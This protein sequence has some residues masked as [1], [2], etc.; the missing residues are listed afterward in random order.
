MKSP[1]VL[2]LCFSFRSAISSVPCYKSAILFQAWVVERMGRFHRVLEPG[3]NVLIP[4][5][6]KVKYVQS[7]KE[8]AIDVPKQGAITSGMLLV[9][10]SGEIVRQFFHYF[11][12]TV[13][14]ITTSQSY[15]SHCMIYVTFR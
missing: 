1:Y 7:L 5:L 4:L 15:S 12:L 11:F 10:V 3:I 8:I 6:D 13:E 14:L 9:P 2:R